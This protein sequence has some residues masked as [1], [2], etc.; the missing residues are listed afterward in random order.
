[1]RPLRQK[2]IGIAVII[3]FLGIIMSAGA[4]LAA[5]QYK[6][7]FGVPWPRPTQNEYHSMFCDL[8]KK[9]SDGKIEITYF[10]DGQLGTHDE[11]FHAVQEGSVHVSMFAPYVNLVP[12]GMLNWMP[13]TIQS[14][15]E[16]KIAFE[17]E[18]GILWKVMESA[19]DEV[20]MH[21]LYQTSFGAYGLGNRQRPI[22]T[23]EDLKNLKMRVSASL[24]L[25]RALE[26][27][28][29]GHG[30]TLQTIPWGDLYDALSKGVVDGCWSMWPSLV[31][32]RHGEVIRYYSDLNFAWDTN[33]VVI[34]KDVW[35]KLPQDL[36]QAVTKAALE[37][38]AK[39]YE[40]QES[41]ESEFKKKLS[42]IKGFELVPLTPAE[43][44]AFRVRS[45][46]P[47]IWDELCKP[48]L[49][50]KYPGQNMTQKIQDELARIHKEVAA[51][52]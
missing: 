21:M 8:V 40:R 15:E 24:G 13:W 27:M 43:R 19:Y 5:P 9:Y 33:N 44:E 35:K 28:G 17:A 11:H 31:E 7:K 42:A 23:P 39:L 37:V 25:V 34:N 2:L 14:W 22:R 18:K 45:N 52:K 29:K 1:M 49:E 46:T 32:E 47:A 12:G 41:L 4:A 16:A 6:W 30:M 51:K 20:G 10:P 48:W 38:E 3:S 26:N 50:K 36:K